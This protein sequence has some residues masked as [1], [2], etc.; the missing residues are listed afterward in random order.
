MK[1]DTKNILNTKEV[2]LGAL[3]IVL[4]ITIVS[5]LVFQFL[6][7]RVELA[8]EPENAVPSPP[9][10]ESEEWQEKNPDIKIGTLDLSDKKPK[11]IVNKEEYFLYPDYKLYYSEHGFS[12]KDRV[13]IQGRVAS[14]LEG[15]RFVIGSIELASE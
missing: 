1:K 10:S 7:E 3:L 13:R 11:L 14:P 2:Y 12:D 5:L 6:K 15:G 4:G 9:L 8:I